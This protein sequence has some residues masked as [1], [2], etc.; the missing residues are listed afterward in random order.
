MSINTYL[1]VLLHTVNLTPKMS[2]WFI[3][4][5]FKLC[6][7]E[8]S[9]ST[10]VSPRELHYG[11]GEMLRRWTFRLFYHNWFRPFLSVI[12]GCDEIL[13]EEFPSSDFK[14]YSFKM[15]FWCDLRNSSTQDINEIFL[16][17]RVRVTALFW[18]LSCC[19]SW[20]FSCVILSTVSP[21]GIAHVLLPQKHP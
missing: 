17:G 6:V 3:A 16:V 15:P 8:S 19:W 10:E 1:W 13:L 21:L 9:N 5:I 14:N 11:L 4:S 7:I 2:V 18:P 12:L 20:F